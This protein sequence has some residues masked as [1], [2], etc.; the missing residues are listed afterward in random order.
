MR[1]LRISGLVLM[2][3]VAAAAVAQ[4]ST[5]A[6]PIDK[7]QWLERANLITAAIQEDASNLPPDIQFILPGRLGEMWDKI[8]AKRAQ[9]WM[10][11]AIA[12][13]SNPPPTESA[14]QRKAR[15]EAATAWWP[16]LNKTDPAAA[17]RVLDSMISEVQ[18]NNSADPEGWWNSNEAS[19]LGS[20]VD[21]AVL[22]V[23]REDPQRAFQLAEKLLQLR[24][25]FSVTAA[26]LDLKAFDAQLA[27][28]FGL[29]AVQAARD[30]NYDRDSF[31][32]LAQLVAPLVN[33]P[34][35]L[36]ASEAV[37]AQILQ[38]LAAGMLRP[39]QNAADQKSICDL[40]MPV[41]TAMKKF[42][43]EQQGLLRAAVDKCKGLNPQ[44]NRNVTYLEAR[45][46]DAAPGELLN[47]A[48]ETSDARSR[49]S[50]KEEAARQAER[51]KDYLRAFEIM[52]SFTA[53]ERDAW[54][55]WSRT[56][57][58]EAQ[59]AIAAFYRAHDLQGVQQLIARV[60][61]NQR[62][63][64]MLHAADLGFRSKDPA[65]GITML[66]QARRELEKNPVTD[67][68]YLYLSLLYSYAHE[69]PE[70]ST[71][72]LRLAVKGLNDFKVPEKAKIKPLEPGWRLNPIMMPPTLLD[73]DPQMVSAAIA[74]VKSPQARIAMRLGLLQACLQRYQGPAKPPAR[75]ADS[76]PPAPPAPKE[77]AK[78][79][80]K[81][82]AEEEK[83]N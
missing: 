35:N 59:Q 67:D 34:E 33:R 19:F 13:I 78:P 56:L 55:M 31:Y 64:M 28:R 21:S 27:D 26:Y 71:S 2:I 49:A 61:D 36:R 40:A 60:P 38:T 57:Q 24:A 9:A 83:K 54:V 75:K 23:A 80:S 44:I 11:Q 69:V 18:R 3:A 81:P 51:E 6:P 58:L 48:A 1:A 15:L 43:P 46:R 77:D 76:K 8:D 5:P 14:E 47:Q 32:A 20:A 62:A 16:G 7:A 73:S 65:Y 39:V 17:D 25:A 30:N 53:E 29:E 42:P 45:T 52:E 74:E 70:E 63:R 68:Y 79:P 41:T 72:V 50:L 12:K 66:T 82:A 4:S 10:D 37:S 22:T